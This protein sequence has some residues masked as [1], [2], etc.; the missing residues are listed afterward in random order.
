[1]RLLHPG[2]MG[3]IALYGW[4]C[5]VGFSGRDG[6]ACVCR[7][8]EVD[9]AYR[10]ATAVFVGRVTGMHDVTGG[11][12]L[13]FTV[14]RAWKGIETGSV[15]VVTDTLCGYLPWSRRLL[16]YAADHGT[17]EL[18][19]RL[20]SRTR[21]A[22]EAEADLKVLGPPAHVVET[23]PRS[24][25]GRV[26]DVLPRMTLE[27]VPEGGAQPVRVRI[28]GI[29]FDHGALG[30]LRRFTLGKEVIVDPI[31][32]E[33]SS[34]LL[35]DVYLVETHGRRMISLTG[36]LLLHGVAWWD[37][38]NSPDDTVLEWFETHGSQPRE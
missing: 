1:M 24:F 34:P 7:T 26:T 31:D 29:K 3:Q 23:T 2:T 25:R 33:E 4:L 13:A 35:A 10:D 19:V 14:E 9:E 16:V 12:R 15:E 18:W 30:E 5:L 36:D 17:G 22:Y 27:V 11:V 38:V 28:A 6:M 21:P 20:C 37:R 32:G 8:P